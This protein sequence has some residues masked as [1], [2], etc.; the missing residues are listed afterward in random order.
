MRSAAGSLNLVEPR[1]AAVVGKVF[2]LVDLHAPDRPGAT[3]VIERRGWRGTTLLVHASTAP[4]YLPGFAP[5]A[6]DQ[7]H[8][9]A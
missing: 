3:L 1:G 4:H 5:P 6:H 9:S 8:Q 2:Q 7:R